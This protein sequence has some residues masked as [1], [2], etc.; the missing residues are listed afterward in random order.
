MSGIQAGDF[1]YMGV[2]KVH[3]REVGAQAAMLHIGNVSALDLGVTTDT[4]EQKDYTA[5]GGGTVAEVHRISAIELSMTLHDLDKGNISRAFLGTGSSVVAGTVAN[6][7]IV[8]F[9]GGF[10][11]T[12]KPIDTTENVIVVNGATTYVLGTDYTVSAGGITIV[13]GGAITDG[14]TLEVTYTTIDHDN[15][16]AITENAKEYELYFEG[17]NE[18]KDGR[19]V[20]VHIY[21]TKLSPTDKLS[22]I[23]D[24]FASFTVKSKLL[25]DNSKKGAGISKYFKVQIATGE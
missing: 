22:L 2:G 16:E 1:S 10:I 5:V 13:A 21:R 19:S 17:M 7:P 20:N 18:A 6:E 15:V 11:P 24:D 14:T 4:K 9:A 8:A 25:R 23:N 12:A 3:L